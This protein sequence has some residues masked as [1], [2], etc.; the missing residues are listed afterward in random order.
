MILLSMCN[1]VLF[2]FIYSSVE[3]DTLSIKKLPFRV[4]F[5]NQSS[6]IAYLLFVRFHKKLSL[7][8]FSTLLF[9]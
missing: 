5:L 4:L 9:G 2:E 7:S 1:Y 3:K 8:I 6:V